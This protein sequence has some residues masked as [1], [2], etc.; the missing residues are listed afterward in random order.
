MA[1]HLFG[2]F[3]SPYLIGEVAD[4]IGLRMPVLVTGLLLVPAGLVLLLWRNT[5]VRD[6]KVQPA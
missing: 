2:D 6:M 3:P 4:H 1:I 5:L